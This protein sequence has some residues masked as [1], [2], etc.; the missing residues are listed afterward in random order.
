MFVVHLLLTGCFFHS[1]SLV[2][3]FDSLVG[4][5]EQGVDVL[6]VL[7][8][9]VSTP[10]TK[11][12]RRSGLSM[13][14]TQSCAQ[15]MVQAMQRRRCG[16]IFVPQQAKFLE[17]VVNAMPVHQRALLFRLGGKSLNPRFTVNPG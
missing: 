17:N 8:W 1:C 4:L 11:P 13:L 6:T 2:G 16:T 7:P 15:E 12:L 3:F 14:S 10:M 9:F 5:E